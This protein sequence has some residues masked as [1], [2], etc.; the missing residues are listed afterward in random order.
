M[1]EVNKAE[2]KTRA[3]REVQLAI[4]TGFLVV[5]PDLGTDQLNAS[6][7]RFLGIVNLVDFALHGTETK[8]EG[9]EGPLGY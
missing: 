7:K 5:N 4:R 8:G 2:I 3:L 6:L 9:N 1:S